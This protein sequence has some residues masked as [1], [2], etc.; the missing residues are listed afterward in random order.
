MLDLILGGWLVLVTVLIVG[1]ILSPR[2]RPALIGVVI[3]V[4]I[5]PLAAVAFLVYEL[6]TTPS[7][8]G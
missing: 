8:W 2:L 6:A 1:T 7:H 3:V 5:V 4:V